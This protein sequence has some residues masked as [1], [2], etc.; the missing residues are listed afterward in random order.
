[1]KRTFCLISV[2]MMFFTGYSQTDNTK[3]MVDYINGCDKVF[4]KNYLGA[5]A[6]FS[7]AIKRDSGFL[8]AYENRGVAKY[9]LKDYRGAIADFTKA[10]EINPD[11]YNTFGRRGW[12]KLRLQDCSGA[13]ADFT[14]AIE[15]SLDAA[16][17]YNARGQAKYY[18]HDYHGAMADFN[19]VI[20]SWSGERN[21]RS[22][23]FYWRGLVKINLGQ[24]AGGCLDLNKA[25]KLGY[26]EAFKVLEI[27]CH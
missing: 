26:A 20:R 8:Q 10:L 17:F 2:F 13:I 7:W 5:I 12:A 9:Y 21:Q 3:A 25:G 1:M 4:R 18:L 22:E 24:K 19:K 23:S 6:D 27:Y 15:S 11:D 14:K 16:Q